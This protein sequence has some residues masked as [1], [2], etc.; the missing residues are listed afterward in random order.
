MTPKCDLCGR[1]LLSKTVTEWDGT[2][3]QMGVCPATPDQHKI[4]ALEKHVSELEAEIEARGPVAVTKRVTP[5]GERIV[6][7]E[8]ELVAAKDGHATI[9]LQTAALLTDLD[10]VAA[11]RDAF[12]SQLRQ[13]QERELALREWVRTTAQHPAFCGANWAHTNGAEGACTCGKG[14]I[15]SNTSATAQEI[16]ER[17]EREALEKALD[18]AHLAVKGMPHHY[19]MKLWVREKELIEVLVDAILGEPHD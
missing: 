17:I 13:A 19:K 6:E 11:D 2:S 15:L 16:V 4:A 7:L 3:Y 9:A 18:R 8:R 12:Q 14:E 10:Q 5:E 1:E